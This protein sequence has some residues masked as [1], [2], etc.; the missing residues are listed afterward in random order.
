MK[1]CVPVLIEKPKSICFSSIL[2]NRESPEEIPNRKD[3]NID[4]SSMTKSDMVPKN[5]SNEHP[6][7]NSSFQNEKFFY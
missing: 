5:T 3:N 4:N 7:S 1:R 2:S 6:K